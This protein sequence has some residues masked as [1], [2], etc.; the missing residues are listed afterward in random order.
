MGG[1]SILVGVE[2]FGKIGESTDGRLWSGISK[3][4]AKCYLAVYVL[5]HSLGPS[6]AVLAFEPST[7]GFI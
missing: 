2:I 7:V 4:L 6:V 1:V 3:A 5:P